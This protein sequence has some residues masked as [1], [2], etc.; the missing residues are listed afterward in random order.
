MGTPRQHRRSGLLLS[1]AAVAI[2]GFVSGTLVHAS[3]DAQPDAQGAH[4]QGVQGIGE[5]MILVIAGVFET[6]AEAEAFRDTHPFGD[7]AGYFVDAT[8]NYR[9]RRVYRQESPSYV[10]IACPE[11]EDG[12][13]PFHLLEDHPNLQRLAPSE[14]RAMLNDESRSNCGVLGEVPCFADSVAPLSAQIRW[15]HGRWLAV[16]A[17]RTLDGA[18]EFVGLGRRAGVENPLVV[19]AVKLNGPYVGLGMESHPL[20]PGP[21]T[22]PLEQQESYQ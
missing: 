6:Q 12:P 13:K 8:D 17:F 1:V 19:Q 22:E 7:S 10:S 5:S 20:E 18:S 21:L 15:P 16:S 14:A 9:F 2:L 3:P 11:Q 4:L